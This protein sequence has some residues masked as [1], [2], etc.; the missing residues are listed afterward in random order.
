[1]LNFRNSMSTEAKIIFQGTKNPTEGVVFKENSV[2]SRR[3]YVLAI[4]ILTNYFRD[5]I[6]V[7][8]RTWR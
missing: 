6:I 4:G 3:V 7:S 8:H 1:M 2:R 5:T